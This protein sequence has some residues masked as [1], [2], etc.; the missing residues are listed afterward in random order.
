MN[1]TSDVKTRVFLLSEL[2]RDFCVLFM[3]SMKDWYLSFSYFSLMYKLNN[4]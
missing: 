2:F 4:H 3:F 1:E